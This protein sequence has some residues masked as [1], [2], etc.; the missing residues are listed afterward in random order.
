M[1]LDQTKD[2]YNDHATD[3][4]DN[5]VTLP[6]GDPRIG[7]LKERFEVNSIPQLV[8]MKGTEEVVSLNAR[9]EV[10]LEGSQAYNKWI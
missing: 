2:Q 3:L 5:W 1:L 7:K 6:F 9:N 4:L 8:I 10:F